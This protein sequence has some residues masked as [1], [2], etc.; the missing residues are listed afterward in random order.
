MADNF[1]TLLDLM[2]ADMYNLFTSV[3][4]IVIHNELRPAFFWSETGAIYIDPYYL[5]ITQ[6]Q[7]NT[8]SKDPD[9]RSDFGSEL[10]FVGLAR[11]TKDGAHAFASGN[12]RSTNNTLYALSAVLFHELAHARD[13]FPTAEI[14]SPNITL[15]P[16]ELADAMI[17][18]TASENLQSTYPL[19]NL[20]LINMAKVM[21][22]GLKADGAQKS[23]TASQM[24]AYLETEGANDDYAYN[25]SQEDAAMLF[26]EVMMKIHFDI[27]RELVYATPLNDDQSSCA[28][29][30]FDFTAINRFAETLVLPR[31]TQVIDDM[32]PGHSHA[33]FLTN[34]TADGVFT[35][36]MPVASART[37]AKPA[38]KH[39]NEGFVQR[40]WH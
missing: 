30:T 3:T 38:D 37:L 28:D 36:C 16:G 21:Y 29:F 35:W 14:T 5:W 23:I 20:T 17:N 34:P 11:Y 22:R 31:A 27:D 25:T 10:R 9:F 12:T 13:R 18:P 33:A 15:T 7:Y 6:A 39:N 2:P 1:S 26:E 4:A 19:T 40:R 8:I 24:G 32:L